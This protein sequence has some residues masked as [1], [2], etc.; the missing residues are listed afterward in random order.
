MRSLR[1]YG[2]TAQFR[3]SGGKAGQGIGRGQLFIGRLAANAKLNDGAGQITASLAGRRGSR[4]ERERSNLGHGRDIQQI[5]GRA[6]GRVGRLADEGR[7]DSLNL[8]FAR[9]SLDGSSIK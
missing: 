3:E 8:G 4:F 6:Q 1:N 2:V 7:V 5:P 9:H